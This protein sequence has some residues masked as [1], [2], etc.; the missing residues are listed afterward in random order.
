MGLRESHPLS[1]H[2]TIKPTKHWAAAATVAATLNYS[3]KISANKHASLESSPRG[4]GAGDLACALLC[5]P[6]TDGQKELSGCTL[7]KAWSHC[8]KPK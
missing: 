5:S 3:R 2:L 8:L 4:H 6:G 7:P 1:C